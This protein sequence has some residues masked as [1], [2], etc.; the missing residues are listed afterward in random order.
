MIFFADENIASI[1]VIFIGKNAAMYIYFNQIEMNAKTFEELLIVGLLI[2]QTEFQMDEKFDACLTE[3]LLPD[4]YCLFS[5]SMIDF[6]SGIVFRTRDCDGKHEEKHE[7]ASN[8]D[9]CTPNAKL[10][11][12]SFFKCDASIFCKF[13]PFNFL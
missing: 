2:L 8:S 5:R 3:Q 6:T 7:K 9:V 12:L 1:F 4:S 10:L 13:Y 11:S